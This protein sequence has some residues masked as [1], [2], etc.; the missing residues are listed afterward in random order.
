VNLGTTEVSPSNS[1]IN[2]PPTPPT[3]SLPWLAIGILLGALAVGLALGA[4]ALGIAL[5]R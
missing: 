5:L 2:R 1:R 3:K 4:T